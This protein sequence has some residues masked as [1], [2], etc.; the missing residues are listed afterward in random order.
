MRV[1]HAPVKQSSQTRVSPV[2]APRIVA[3]AAKWRS[4]SLWLVI[5]CSNTLA[6]LKPFSNLIAIKELRLSE[7][8]LRPLIYFN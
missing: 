1:S 2:P 4:Y 5:G 6:F 3:E 8:G 7:G